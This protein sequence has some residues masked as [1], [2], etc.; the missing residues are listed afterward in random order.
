VR[1]RVAG[2]PVRIDPFFIITMAML[3]LVSGRDGV[4]IVEWVVVAAFSIL[5]HELGHAFAFRRFGSSAEITLTGF[6]GVTVGTAQPPLRSIVVSVAGPFVGFAFGLFFVWLNRSTTTDSLLVANA[7]AD[8]VF[9]NLA[10]GIFNLL[11]ILPLDGGSVVASFLEHV[12]RGGGQRIAHLVSVV[13]AV[14]LAAAG[15]GLGQ[16]FVALFALYF[17]YLNYQSLSRTNDQP[18]LHEVEVGRAALLQ[19][20]LDG[21]VAAGERVATNAGS[22]RVRTAAVELLAWAHLAAGRP[23]QADAALARI[24]GGV[25]ASQLVRTMVELANGRPVPPLAP[26]FGACNDAVAAIVASRLVAEA[27]RLDSVL[28]E[29]SGLAPAQ[30]VAALRALQL[31]L[32]QSARF[33]DSARVG[34]LLFETVEEPGVAY[35]VACS[36][37]R[38]GNVGEALVWLNHAVDRGYRDTAN[39]DSDPDLELVRGTDGFRAVRSS[40]EA[41]PPATPH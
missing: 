3:G 6:G 14:A 34:A 36:H 17:A 38:A 2:F 22:A 16:P 15:L 39:L 40:I 7:L 20:D 27:G 26:A 21:A 4:L 12:T 32:H 33:E 1:F 18:Q 8:L 25:S 13:A 29:I 28:V 35:N 23:A 5:V 31:G 30:M 10:W 41:G 37:A 19:G 11:P 24:G 9:V